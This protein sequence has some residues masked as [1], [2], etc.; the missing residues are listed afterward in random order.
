M[1]RTCK[2]DRRQR[3]RTAS[4]AATAVHRRAVKRHV[5][6]AV[7]VQSGAGRVRRAV[8]SLQATVLSGED[9]GRCGM[10][11]AAMTETTPVTPAI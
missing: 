6:E 2:R 10:F 11:A 8:A 7:G 9:R 3:L 1:G 5:C 4:G